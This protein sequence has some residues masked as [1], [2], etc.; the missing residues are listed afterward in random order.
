M[1]NALLLANQQNAA[2]QEQLKTP[3]QQQ[4]QQQQQQ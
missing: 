4:K 3:L 1:R 2:L